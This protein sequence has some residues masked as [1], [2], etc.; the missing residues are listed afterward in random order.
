MRADQDMEGVPNSN[1]WPRTR[2]RP[3]ESAVSPTL[4]LAAILRPDGRDRD[5]GAVE[6]RGVVRVGRDGRRA[7]R[8]PECSNRAALTF[9]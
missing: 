4:V 8:Y 6:R 3:A 1:Y 9:R 5:L 7:M 2:R